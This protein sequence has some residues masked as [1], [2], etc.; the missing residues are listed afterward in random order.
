MQ[1]QRDERGSAL[2][3]NGTSK[4]TLKSRL[5]SFKVITFKH[6]DNDGKLTGAFEA[7]VVAE[8]PAEA[9]KVAQAGFSTVGYPKDNVR[10]VSFVELNPAEAEEWRQY[11]K[12]TRPLWGAVAVEQEASE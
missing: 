7:A 1:P 8:T 6:E 4:R 9:V 5:Y 3:P 2:N 12:D 10:V 11:H